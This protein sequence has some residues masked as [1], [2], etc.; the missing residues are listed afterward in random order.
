MAISAEEEETLDAIKRWWHESGKFIAMGI[1]SIGVVY[2]GWQFWDNS[3]TG[4][5]AE[6]SAIYDQ[7]TGIAVV[8]PGQQVS[9]AERERAM[10]L[11]ERLKSDYSN[12]VYALYAALFGARLS[13]EANDLAAAKQELEWLLANAR[14]GFFSSTDPTLVALAQLR[15]GRVLLA[16]GESEQALTTISGAVPGALAAEFDELRGD[17][18]LSQGQTNLALTAYEAALGA[19]NASPIL[20]LKLNEL[21]GSR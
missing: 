7:L 13:V 2:F 6:A 11:V 16:Q 5:A 12:S 18:Y 20:Q 4:V 14:S 15:L 9:S 1:A 10:M 21:Q 3:R 19:G 8:E 17:I